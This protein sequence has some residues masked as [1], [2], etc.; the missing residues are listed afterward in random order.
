M[1]HLGI[2]GYYNPF[3]GEAQVNSFLPAFMQPFVISHEMAHQSGI[4]AEDDANLLA[5][6]LG[7]TS[8][9]S[10][11][12]YSA[13]LNVWLYTHARVRAVDTHMANIFRKQLNPITK[14]HLDTLRAIRRKFDSDVNDYSSYLYDEYLK[15]HN[16]KEGIETYDKVSISAWAW[17]R[18]RDSV[19]TKLLRLP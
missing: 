7:A 14:S 6:A 1:Q 13:Y 16:Q 8:G 5:Y 19:T 10:S 3:T 11:F 12:N 9:D 2:Q 17:E 4:A 15:L 18:Q